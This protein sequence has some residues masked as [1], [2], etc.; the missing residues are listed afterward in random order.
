[1]LMASNPAWFSETSYALKVRL[2]NMEFVIT[3]ILDKIFATV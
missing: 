3:N 1:M 2:H